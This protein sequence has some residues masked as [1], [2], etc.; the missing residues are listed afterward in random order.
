MI[1]DV[2]PGSRIWIPDPEVKKAPDP[3]SR[4]RNTDL[5]FLLVYTQQLYRIRAIHGPLLQV[6]QTYGSVNCVL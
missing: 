1:L 5:E 2:H 6:C 3:G 4:I